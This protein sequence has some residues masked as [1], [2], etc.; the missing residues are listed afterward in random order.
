MFTKANPDK[1]TETT[2]P[3]AFEY[4]SYLFTKANP[5]KG[6]ETITRDCEHIPQGV[7]FTKDNPDKGTET[8][9]HSYLQIL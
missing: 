8:D 3:L 2:I 5:D 4:P 6:T 7:L 9:I 1:G